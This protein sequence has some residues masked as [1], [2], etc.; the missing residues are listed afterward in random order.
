MKSVLLSLLVTMIAV[1]ASAQNSLTASGAAPA[2]AN[3][4]KG[5]QAGI[6]YSNLTDASSKF[7]ADT[8]HGKVEDTTHSG[9]HLGL[10]GINF[11]YMDK[12][13]FGSFGFEASGSILK[14][15]NGSE[16]ETK[17]TIYK[18]Q[19]AAVVPFN[20]MIS[21]VGGLNVSKF[22]NTDSDSD[23]Q[24]GA[25]L[26]LGIQFGINNVNIKVGMQ[27]LSAQTKGT[28]YEFTDGSYNTYESKNDL[29]FSGFLTQVSY[30]F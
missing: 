5:I 2:S 19:G 8:N 30:V 15:I 27:A 25:G 20:D 1:T 12:Y 4:T 16:A 14:P 21:A 10:M 3:K 18:I 9:M 11:G 29:V 13:A 24:A 26:D 17:L 6:V 23:I 22:T 28:V 7:S